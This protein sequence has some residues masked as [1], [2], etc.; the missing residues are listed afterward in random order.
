M[1]DP[2]SVNDLSA[3]ATGKLVL[4]PANVK[5]AMLSTKDDMG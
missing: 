2:S 1:Q 3:V 5:E 4:K